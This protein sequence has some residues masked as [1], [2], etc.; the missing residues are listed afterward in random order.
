MATPDSAP[1]DYIDA[2]FTIEGLASPVDEQKL[3]QAFTGREGIRS[4]T[5][6]GSKLMVEYE[7]V[8]I[9]K[10]QIVAAIQ[11]AGFRVGDVESAPASPIVEAIFEEHLAHAPA[12]PPPGSPLPNSPPAHEH[13]SPSR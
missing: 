1:H 2:D 9:H 13:E 10:T 3:L 4:L 6:S 5:L 8:Y 12:E 7:P 11:A